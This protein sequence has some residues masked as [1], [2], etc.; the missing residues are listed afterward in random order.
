MPYLGLI[1]RDCRAGDSSDGLQVERNGRVLRRTVGQILQV[2]VEAL[3]EL[4]HFD[5]L[6]RRVIH[7]V[8]DLDAYA[9]ANP[10]IKAEIFV[11]GARRRVALTESVDRVSQGERMAESVVVASD[12]DANESIRLSRSV[13][14]GDGHSQN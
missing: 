13:Q 14:V 8:H 9:T 3:F 12:A 5:L 10:V 1:N 7:L 11:A 4:Q 6:N 2:V